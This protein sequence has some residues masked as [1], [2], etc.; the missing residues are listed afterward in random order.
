MLFG[1]VNNLDL[2]PYVKPEIKTLITSAI[3]VSKHNPLGRYELGTEGVF[4]VLA[5][6]ET[7]EKSARK[8]EIHKC[9]A[10]IQIVLEGNEII[11]FSNHLETKY[12]GIMELE[13][14]VMFFDTVEQEQFVSLQNGDFA[15]FY[16]NQVHRPLCATEQPMQVKKAIVKIPIDLL[17]W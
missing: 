2:L 11:G 9:Y 15:L 13:S 16:P 6:A 4:V 5:E 12:K 3:E 7:Q 17:G 1:N 14:D 10:D 8:A